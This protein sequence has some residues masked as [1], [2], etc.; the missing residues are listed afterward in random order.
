MQRMKVLTVTGVSAVMALFWWLDGSA[1]A[2][3][4]LPQMTIAAEPPTPASENAPAALPPLPRDRQ[5]TEVDGE[6]ASDAEGHL[7]VTPDVR[8]VFD[9][10][11]MSQGAESA[12]V[13]ETRVFAYIEENLPPKAALEAKALWR[14]YVAMRE[15]F[16]NITADANRPRAPQAVEALETITAK[17]FSP[18]EREALFGD[19]IT[20]ARATAPAI[21][22]LEQ[23]PNMTA[24][25]R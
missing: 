8:H 25:E 24:Q 13:I 16:S 20:R 2:G 14:K 22:G 9:Y 21:L 11:L 3:G 17:Y 23:N 18:A 19:D 12:V 15:A 10:F 7:R 6:L 5:G 1:S 4:E